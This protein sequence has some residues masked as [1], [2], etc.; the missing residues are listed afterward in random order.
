MKDLFFKV[1]TGAMLCSAA[2]ALVTDAQAQP[3]YWQP[4]SSPGFINPPGSLVVGGW[5]NS[6]DFGRTDLRICRLSDNLG[7]WSYGG[8]YSGSCNYYSR[9]LGR[10]HVV[11]IG[12]DLLGGDS[13]PRW[14]SSNHRNH[15][16]W[17][18]LEG[19]TNGETYGHPSQIPSQQV[20]AQQGEIESLCRIVQGDGAYI[21]T[22]ID[23][24]CFAAWQGLELISADYEIV[25]LGQD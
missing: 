23:G 6:P 16:N 21:G 4:W 13:H 17:N 12:F 19:Q 22:I 20:T 5:W 7:R 9:P 25:D 24:S 18:L 10:G 2:A 8:F 15:R 1:L 11:S 3:M 14:I